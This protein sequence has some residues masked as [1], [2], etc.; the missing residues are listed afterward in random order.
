MSGATGRWLLIATGVVVAASVVAAVVSMGTPGQQRM[1]RQDER[2]VR[3]LDRLKDEIESWAERTGSLPADMGA[4]A[5]PGVRLS[6]QD[7]FT[8]KPY[9][10]L[11]Q[12]RRTYRL[13]AV[14]ETDTAAVEQGRYGRADW[15]HPAG[16]YCFDLKLPDKA[17][18][19]V[20]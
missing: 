10:Y 19:E 3:D 11:A 12:G 2:R 18:V 15:P 1:V 20:E 4:L 5:R 17:K 9:G 16:R 6:A 14:F 13:C 8:G 7:P